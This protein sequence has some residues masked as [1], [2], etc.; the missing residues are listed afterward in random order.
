MKIFAVKTDK[1]KEWKTDFPFEVEF[2]EQDEHPF[3]KQWNKIRFFGLDLDEPICVIDLD[4]KFIN[5][6]EKLIDYPC[7]KGEFIGIPAWWKD[8]HDVKYQING[9]FYKFWPSTTKYI[10]KKFQRNYEN[11]MKMYFENG[12]TSRV[13]FGEQFFVEDSVRERLDLKLVPGTWVTKWTMNG[14]PS[15]E[16]IRIGN[17]TYP[18]DFLFK[19]ENFNPEIKFIHFLNQT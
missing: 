4:T 19:D 5:D 2:L 13:G 16:E 7:E 18:G 11:I 8:T 3:A 15:E 6:W 14:N 10:E 1:Y 12:I 17:E 9:G